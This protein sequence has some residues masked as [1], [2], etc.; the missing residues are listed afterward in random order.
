MPTTIPV[1]LDGVEPALAR[2]LA[3]G[4]AAAEGAALRYADLIAVHE[5]ADAIRVAFGG[6]ARQ[7]DGAEVLGRSVR[8]GGVTLRSLSLGGVV[9]LGKL[10]SWAELIDQTAYDILEAWVYAHSWSVQA[11]G[12]LTD[13]V[14]A[15]EIVEEWSAQ[16][17][18]TQEELRAAVEIVRDPPRSE[19]DGEQLDVPRV[20][21]RL[22]RRYGGSEARWLETP[23]ARISALAEAARRNDVQDEAEMAAEMGTPARGQARDRSRA[24]NAYR[25]T[26]EG[27]TGKPLVEA[28]KHG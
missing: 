12:R 22:M 21:D 1:C 15:G 13:P 19:A 24:I 6:Q 8:V 5:R 17:T 11:L 28:A 25:K 2:D 3:R 20:M 16:L 7:R 27:L 23:A 9:A 4:A 10:V 26:V 18:C 14:A